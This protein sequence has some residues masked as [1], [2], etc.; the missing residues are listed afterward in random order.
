MRI[1]DW[2]SDVCSSDLAAV[3]EPQ[4]TDDAAPKAVDDEEA[5]IAHTTY[6]IKKAFGAI[7]RIDKSG[8]N[9]LGLHQRRKLDAF[10]ERYVAR[11]RKSKEY[12]QA[13][14]RHMADPRVVNGFKP[15][16][17]EMTYQIVVERSK[18]SHLWDLDGNEYVDALN[19]LGMSLFGW[20]PGFVLDSVR[21]QLELGYEIGPQHPLAGDVTR[22]VCDVTDRKSVVS[23]KSVSVRVDLGGRRII[24]QKRKHD[25]TDINMLKK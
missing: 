23:G 2:S 11:T 10:I 4:P 13:N 8:G 24:K 12:T 18:G 17:K 22:L 14:R 16:L 21:E 19:G 25:T 3:A 5:A 9:D 7:A 20:Q 6:D 1:S 15:M